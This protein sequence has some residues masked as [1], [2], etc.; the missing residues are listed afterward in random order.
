MRDNKRIINLICNYYEK[1]RIRI[2][3]KEG[4]LQKKSYTYIILC[5]NCKYTGVTH[6]FIF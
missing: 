4:L 2:M 3:R 6:I 1:V 5:D